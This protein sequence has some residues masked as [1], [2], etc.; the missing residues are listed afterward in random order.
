MWLLLF[1]EGDFKRDIASLRSEKSFV[2][3]RVLVASTAGASCC[4]G[5]IEVAETCG[6]E[7]AWASNGLS[8]LNVFI[9]FMTGVCIVGIL[10]VHAPGGVPE[11][12]TVIDGV[13][14]PDDVSAK[15]SYSEGFGTFLNLL[16]TDGKLCARSGA[17]ISAKSPWS[18]QTVLHEEPVC[19][20]CSRVVV[21]E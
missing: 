13:A 4:R 10:A 21:T 19:P 7:E 6:D 1:L 18:A 3:V 16:H 17:M 15:E 8:R 2:L 20:L 5:T 9:T 12:L 11:W 14:A